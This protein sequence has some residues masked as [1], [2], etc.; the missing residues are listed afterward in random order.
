VLRY[1]KFL[2][3]YG[4]LEFRRRLVEEAGVLLLPSSLF[5]SELLPVPNDRF[6][7]GFGRDGIDAGIA[8]WEDFLLR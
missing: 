3:C 2:N 1:R 5:V 6:R 7:V 4:C 8:A